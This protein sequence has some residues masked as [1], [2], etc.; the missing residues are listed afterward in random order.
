MKVSKLSEMKTNQQPIF[1]SEEDIRTKVVYGWLRDHGFG[2]DD[3]SVEF[4]FEIRLGRGIYTVKGKSVNGQIFR[5]RAD[6]IVRTCDG[7]NLMVVEVKAPGEPLDDDVREQGISYARLLRKGGMAP[8][9]VLTNGSESKIFDT[10]SGE[11]ISIDLV[12][13]EHPHVKSKYR[14]TADDLKLRTHALEHL[15]S[16]SEE[17][18]IAFCRNQVDYRMRL[19]RSDDPLTGKKYIPSLYVERKSSQE[20]LDKFLAEPERRVLIVTGPPQVGKTNFICHAVENYLDK[21]YPCLFYPAI[22][23]EKGLLDEIKEDFEWELGTESSSYQIIHNKLCRIAD[24]VGKRIIIFIDGWNEA[25]RQ[26]AY[27]VDRECERLAKENITVVT[28]FTNMAASRLLIDPTGN[29]SHIAEAAYISC[30][31]VELLTI[32]PDRLTQPNRLL[33]KKEISVVTLNKYNDEEMA[34][35]YKRYARF[36]NV[37]IPSGHKYIQDPFLIRIGMQHYRGQ[38]LPDQLDEPKLLAD[39]IHEKAAR[40][41][42]VNKQLVD[43]LLYTLGDRLLIQDKAVSWIDVAHMW[44]MPIIQVPEGLFEAA[45]LSKVND[46]FG[47]LSIDFYNERERDFVIAWWVRKWPQILSDIEIIVQE[48]TQAAQSQIGTSALNWFLKSDRI[49]LAKAATHLSSFPGAL[50]KRFILSNLR[51]SVVQMSFSSKWILE[52]LQQGAED[53]DILV[54]AATANLLSA[55]ADT[56]LDEFGNL[57]SDNPY[58]IGSLIAIE[59]IEDSDI[60]YE[61][62]L[63]VFLDLHENFVGYDD[64]GSPVTDALIKVASLHSNFVCAN[65]LN[66][67][68]YVAPD[69]LLEHVP[70]IFTLKK[71]LLEAN[72]R[73]LCKKGVEQAIQQLNKEYYGFMCPGDLE[74]LLESPVELFEEYRKMQEIC[75]PVIKL[76]LPEKCALDLAHIVHSLCPQA[77]YLVELKSVYGKDLKTPTFGDI[78]AQRYQLPLP[79]PELGFDEQI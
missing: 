66:V 58:I 34:E 76:L 28:S 41:I 35:T 29:P 46:G 51:S 57:I 7:R 61:E 60:F 32:N 12:P 27:T 42:G 23:L 44:G 15:I 11:L 8:F 62:I 71:E 31:E 19:L 64:K 68:G 55:I 67:L 72:I 25:N 45:L 2:P 30:G 75:A 6:A 65:A 17:N 3:I 50:I 54:K 49:V 5:P 38:Q 40:A 26:L 73:E 77:E 78:L 63:N 9:V 16:L 79:I 56:N 70:N 4:A 24:R 59:E 74:H 14:I 18:L 48:F 43:T 36:F 52:V 13:L 69:I 39:F 47:L 37:S 1:V 21:G 10:F 20:K 33:G 53:E 22:A